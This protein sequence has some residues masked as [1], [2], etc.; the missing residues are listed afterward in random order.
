[1]SLSDPG[2]Y[3]SVRRRE[4]KYL[5]VNIESFVNLRDNEN[6]SILSV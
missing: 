5:W 4:K 3:R 2:V 6:N 1:M